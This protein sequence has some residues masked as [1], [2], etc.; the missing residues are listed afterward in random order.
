MCC[1]EEEVMDKEELCPVCKAH[2]ENWKEM[3]GEEHHCIKEE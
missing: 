3:F 2:L 1:Q